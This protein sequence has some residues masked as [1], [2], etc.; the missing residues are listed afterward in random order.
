MN[1]RPTHFSARKSLGQ[2]FLKD[3][4]LID[5]I[6]TSCQL[7]KYDTVLEIGPGQGALTNSIAPK[8]K[9]LIL[10]EKDPRLISFLNEQYKAENVTILNENFL[11]I[12]WND[13]PKNMKIIGNLPYNISTPIIE[14]IIE[15]RHQCQSFHFMVQREYAQRLIGIPGTKDYG[16]LTCYVNYFSKVWRVLSI[17]PQAFRPP[18]KVHSWFMEMTFKKDTELLAKNETQMF[19]IIRNAFQQRRK[20]IHNSFQSIPIEIR[21]TLWNKTEL[22]PNIRAE[23]VTLEQYIQVSNFVEE[24]ILERK[25]F[26]S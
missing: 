7:S 20:M 25:K 17:P 18:P 5:R 22:N 24:L 14:N 2:H 19:A 11:T 6:I 23:N 15:H 3:R 16:S 12:K 1:S 4:N 26:S 8:V 21:D 13:L 10:V 9:K